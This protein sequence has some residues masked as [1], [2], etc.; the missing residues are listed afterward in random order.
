[1]YRGIPGTHNL[2]PL[3]FCFRSAFPR[4]QDSTDRFFQ[5]RKE[6]LVAKRATRATM[7]TQIPKLVFRQRAL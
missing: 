3:L 1:M 7:P 5:P 4:L 6:R 2:I